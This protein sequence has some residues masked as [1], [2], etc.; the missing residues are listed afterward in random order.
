MN[1]LVT[2][3]AGYIGSHT[4]MALAKRGHRV[5]V[6]DNLCLGHRGAVQ[7]GDFVYGDIRDTMTL[8]TTLKKHCI[9]G[10][11]HF[12]AFAAVGESVIDPGKYYDNNVGGTLSIMQA[13]QAEGVGS[14]VAS[15]T[16]AV[17]GQVERVPIEE[18][19][20]KAPINPYGASK[21]FM[22]RILEDFGTAHGIGWASL[23]Y[24]N[25]A[26]ADSEARIGEL[27]DPETHLI[28]RALMAARG[29]LEVLQVFGDD[30]PTADGTCIR[31]YI[32]VCDLADAHVRAI[33]ALHGG[34]K[35]IVCNL[36]TGNGLSVRQ[37]IESVEKV[38]GLRVPLSVGPRRAGD[39]PRLTADASL[40]HTTLGWQ[41]NC[42]DVDSIIS[43]AWKWMQKDVRW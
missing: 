1:I 20:P 36:G 8:R 38:T 21:L 32:H 29:Q 14:V 5:V 11:I 22:E 31:D 35:S 2:G 15:G 12:A 6:Y 9:E 40:A 43:H 4:A 19:F 18:N 41:P 30:Y 34:T 26:G 42:S 33:E 13:M 7:W 37:I 10:V 23:R 25:A 28:P 27:H 24:F 39:P 16:C 3:G 17:Y